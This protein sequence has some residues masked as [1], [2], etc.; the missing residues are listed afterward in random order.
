MPKVRRTPP[1]QHVVVVDTNILWDKDKKLPVCIAFD[2]FWKKNSSLIPMTLNVPDVVFGELHFQQTTSALK[3]LT[4]INDNISELAAITCAP[5]AHKCNEASIKSQ[6][7]AK[8]E[9]WLKGH[10]GQQITT[11]VSKIDW[12]SVVESAVWRKPPFTFDPRT[13]KTKKASETQ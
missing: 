5:Y 1:P 13:K 4:S 12:S 7:R 6:I 10:G 11:P 8:L 2:E 9:K 3:S